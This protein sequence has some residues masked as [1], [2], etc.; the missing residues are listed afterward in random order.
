M[1]ED[2]KLFCPGSS[3]RVPENYEPENKLWV[4]AGDISSKGSEDGTRIA[5]NK[6]QVYGYEGIRITNNV[7]PRPEDPDSP[8]IIVRMFDDQGHDLFDG[9]HI[10]ILPGTTLFQ[11][12]R[13][14]Y[15]EEY[16]Y[17]MPIRGYLEVYVRDLY[18]EYD[19][20]IYLE[21]WH[22]N[23]P[24]PYFPV[25][26]YGR[27]PTSGYIDFWGGDEFSVSGSLIL[28]AGGMLKEGITVGMLGSFI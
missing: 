13:D 20:G 24:F 14:D 22:G 7:T 16:D 11:P 26:F 27:Y 25:A 19:L 23:P 28:P 10:N 3:D 2:Y 5:I 17:K 1:N 6:I 12:F 9:E 4:I 21:F 15:F 8:G 18:G